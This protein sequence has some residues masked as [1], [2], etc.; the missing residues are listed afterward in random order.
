MNNNFLE[1]KVKVKATTRNWK[2]T[3]EL[4]KLA[5]S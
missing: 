4:L 2:T 5:K 1:T 3:N